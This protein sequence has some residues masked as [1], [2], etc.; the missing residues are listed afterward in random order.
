MNRSIAGFI[1]YI[2]TALYLLVAGVAGLGKGGGAIQ[3]MFSAIN[4][5]KGGPASVLV[6]IF[7]LAA[8][9]AGILLL[10]QLFGMEFGIIEIILIA[11]TILWIVFIIVADIIDP[12]GSGTKF[13][14]WLSSLAGHLIVLG[15]IASGTRFFG[16]N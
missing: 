3:E 5:F 1:M 9:V 11:F 12:L 4:L 16:G 10:L 13:W 2:G 6:F 15:V 8:L 14:G 7:S